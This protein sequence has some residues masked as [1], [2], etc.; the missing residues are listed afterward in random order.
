MGA[1]NCDYDGTIGQAA[2]NGLFRMSGGR[3]EIETDIDGDPT[4]LV[5]DT[6]KLRA[7]Y[8]AASG[9]YVSR[10]APQTVQFVDYTFGSN[11][12]KLKSLPQQYSSH[13]EALAPGDVFY[14]GGQKCTITAVDGG[15]SADRTL[16]NG[17]DQTPYVSS[18]TC[19]ETLEANP[20]STSTA[21]FV[22][23]PVEIV[24]PGATTSCTA[25]DYRR[26]TWQN[27][28]VSHSSGGD[29]TV[30]IGT[31]ISGAGDN[32]KVVQGVGGTAALV[33]SGTIAIGDRV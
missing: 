3:Y 10:D 13:P 9:G 7:V 31:A 11:Q 27:Q 29:N 15:Y 18:V 32:R 4:E 23:E 14:L 19:A 25:S 2:T 17:E 1:D 12:P 8:I 28:A 33:D 24:I 21:L 6:S 20:H 5:C 16:R 26:I 30:Q 22:N